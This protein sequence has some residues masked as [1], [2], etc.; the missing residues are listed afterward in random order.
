MAEG[1]GS[2]GTGLEPSPIPAWDRATDRPT[3]SSLASARCPGDPSCAGWDPAAEARSERCL[4]VAALSSE[5]AEGPRTEVAGGCATDP[6]RGS[7]PAPGSAGAGGNGGRTRSNGAPGWARSRSTSA[8]LNAC[9]G[10]SDT[11]PRTVATAARDTAVAPVASAAQAA[12]D[13]QPCLMG[14]SVPCARSGRPNNMLPVSLRRDNTDPPPRRC[15]V[16]VPRG[17]TVGACREFWWSRTTR[18]SARP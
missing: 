14:N 10:V 8:V 1:S 3:V 5:S 12:T 9:T 17:R 4:G 6:D 7:P 18:G 15:A 2:A 16:R 13:S 11:T